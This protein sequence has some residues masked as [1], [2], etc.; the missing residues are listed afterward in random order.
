MN[1]KYFR[2]FIM[3]LML[4][5]GFCPAVSAKSGR[6]PVR[7]VKG[8]R[9]DNS[10]WG[11]VKVTWD[12]AAAADGYWIRYSQ[13][14]SMKNARNIYVNAGTEYVIR[15]LDVRKR[16]YVSVRACRR[17]KGRVLPGVPSK[18][19]KCMVKGRLVVIDPGHQ[20]H[21]NP[22]P[23]PI[24][25]GSEIMKKKVTNGTC[26]TVTKVPEYV[27]VLEVSLKLREELEKR[28][29]Q[30]KMTREVHEVDISNSERAM[31]AN[32]WGADVFLRIHANGSRKRSKNGC[33]TLCCTAK[34]PFP[35]QKVYRRSRKLSEF[36]V[37]H[38]AGETKARNMG[39]HETD[40]MTGINWSEVPVS[41]IEMGYMTNPRE[42]KRMQTEAYQKK[43]VTGLANGVD[44]YFR[45][46]TENT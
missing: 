26:G 23:E 13:D 11:R 8:I 4:A 5:L 15:K 45:R 33:S 17:E 22:E 20:A 32:E 12:A 1:R 18:V 27:L 38:L 36:L 24:G 7:P 19:Y 30:V 35:V 43:I 44:A 40:N 39:V 31:M 14:P 21:G 9:L 3:L 16:V 2:L 25:P 42:D 10:E 6:F 46:K 28:G 41:I 37:N 34:N 29:Y